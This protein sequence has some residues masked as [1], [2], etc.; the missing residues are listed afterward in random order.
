VLTLGGTNS[1]LFTGDIDFQNLAA[2]TF[3]STGPTFWLQ[4]VT[5]LQLNG[6]SVNIGSSQDNSAAIDTGT[7]LVGGPTEAVQNLYGQIPGN[8]SLGGGMFGYPCNT[9]IQ[10]SFS[11]GGK[12]W[13]MNPKDFNLGQ[14]QRSNG[15]CTG[16]IFD[17]GQGAQ[18]SAGTPD[19]IVGDAFLKSVYTVFRTNPNSVGFAELSSAAGG[20]AG[21]PGS[22]S[23]GSSSSSGNGGSKTSSAMRNALGVTT[24]ATFALTVISV[25]A[26]F[27]F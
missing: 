5:Q 18:T 22:G 8:V 3:G 11:F 9:D 23:P 14:I 4:T 13:P 1:S 19:W 27:V 17:V 2:S 10:I 24:S 25:L 6:Q 26:A 15:L 12:S 16:A 21:T 7:T 20:S